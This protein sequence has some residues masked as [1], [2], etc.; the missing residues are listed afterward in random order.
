MINLDVVRM[1]ATANFGEA[2]IGFV[3]LGAVVWV[4][5]YAFAEIYN[6]LAKGR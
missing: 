3:F 1:S 2:L 4:S 6:R 5:I